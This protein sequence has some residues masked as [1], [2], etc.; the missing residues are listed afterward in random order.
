MVVSPN[1]KKLDA[2]NQALNWLVISV[3][4]IS[5]IFVTNLRDP[6]NAPKSWILS[7]SG[8]W[9]FGWLAFQIKVRLKES[10]QK[11]TIIISLLFVSALI[12]DF[13]AT[14]NKYIGMFGTY[15]RRTGLLTYLSLIFFFLSASFL[16]R[17]SNILKV[18]RMT[19]VVGFIVGSYGFS[20]HFGVDPIHWANPYN[21]VIS[22]VGNP[23]FSSALMAILLVLAFGIPFQ[24]QHKKGIKYFAVFEV[25]LLLTT[26]IF[27]QARQGL[28]SGVLGISVI[29]SYLIFK[30]NRKFGYTF[31]VILVIIGI[32][33]LIGMLNKGPLHKLF[34][35]LSVTNRGDYW[36]AG[37]R[38]FKANPIFGVG[39]D[40]YGDN[41]R[42]F[43][44][45][46]Q[47]QRHGPDLI[48]NAAHNVPI[49]F[50]AT[51]GLVLLIAFIAYLI[52]VSWRA[53]ELIR[54]SNVSEKMIAVSLVGAWVTYQSQSFISIDNVGLA[55][56]GYLLGGIVVGLSIRESEKQLTTPN[57]PF[58]Q[59]VS[60]QVSFFN[61]KQ[62]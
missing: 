32:F 50:A 62:Q 16:I 39:L 51:G 37:W 4:I 3:G 26:I 10:I 12:I 34:Y 31:Q 22:T 43:R 6:F 35:K 7:I 17:F 38:M 8:F 33:S 55:I 57:K 18:H 59:P 27:S 25:L 23:D 30:Y 49:Q 48:S 15:Q 14:D 29:L 60:Y 19:L 40:R 5:L 44:D 52:F 36:R 42:L 56:W 20:Q 1:K 13:I 21:S 28:I 61:R 47:S 54:N 46:K 58:A 11:F 41:F 2:E 24:S 9:I 45:S 53:I